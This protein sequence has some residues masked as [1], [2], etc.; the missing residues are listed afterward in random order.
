MTELAKTARVAFSVT[1]RQTTFVFRSLS[2]GVRTRELWLNLS[3]CFSG[4][5][6]WRQRF[7]SSP[8]SSSFTEGGN[9]SKVAPW[10]KACFLFKDKGLTI[11]MEVRSTSRE[12]RVKSLMIFNVFLLPLLHVL[13]YNMYF[14]QGSTMPDIASGMH[15]QASMLRIKGTLEGRK[16]FS[17]DSLCN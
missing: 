4:E 8:S 10:Q 15:L 1:M 6:C 17:H 7:T 11:T 9:F 16:I 14:C 12:A 5:R 2:F 3:S 13:F